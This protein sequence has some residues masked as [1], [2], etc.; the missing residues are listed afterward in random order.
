M[1]NDKDS[2]DTNI[3]PMPANAQNF[4]FPPRHQESTFTAELSNIMDDYKIPIE[5]TYRYLIRTHKRFRMLWDLFTVVLTFY[6]AITVP[7]FVAFYMDFEVQFLLVNLAI[8]VVFVVDILLN[9]IT[10]YIDDEGEVTEYRKIARNYASKMFAVDLISCLPFDVVLAIC[11]FR[12]GHYYFW[13]L[14][15]NMFKMPKLA[16]TSRVISFWQASDEAK[17]GAKM[18]LLFFYICLWVHISGCLWF[19]EITKSSKWT[20]ALDSYKTIEYFYDIDI[21]YQYFTCFYYG[22]WLSMGNDVYPTSEGEYFLSSL[23]MIIGTV[24]MAILLGEVAVIMTN[25]N[26]QQALFQEILDEASQNLSNIGINKELTLKVLNRISEAHNSLRSH[27]E[28]EIFQQYVS[29]SIKYQIAETLYDPVLS[30][31]PVFNGENNLLQFLLKKMKIKFCKDE[32]EIIAEGQDSNCMYFLISG[33]VK[34]LAFNHEEKKNSKVCFL[35]P[36]SHFGEIGLIYNT[37][38]R[39]TAIAEGYCTTAELS[40]NDFFSLTSMNSNVIPKLREFTENYSDPA[41]M[42]ISESLLMQEYFNSLP[43]NLLHEVPFMMNIKKLEKGSYL[44]KPG[45]IFKNI[46]ILIEG[47]LELSVSINDKYIQHLKI[48][49]G[50]ADVSTMRKSSSHNGNADFSKRKFDLFSV[51]GLKR[52]TELFPYIRSDGLISSSKNEST[53][54]INA[55][56]L[57]DFIQEIVLLIIKPGAVLNSNLALCSATTL[58]QCKALDSCVL[59]YLPISHIENFSKQNFSF[60]RAVYISHKR[61]LNLKTI[62]NMQNIDVLYMNIQKNKTSL[63]W[64]EAILKVIIKNR[65]EIRKRFKNM[66][67][68]SSKLRAILACEEA[69]NKELA[70]KVVKGE[71]LP[72]LISEDG[73]MISEKNID[74]TGLPASHP[75]IGKFKSALDELSNPQGY[76]LTLYNNFA[77]ELLNETEKVETMKKDLSGIKDFLTNYIEKNKG[78]SIVESKP[79]QNAVPDLEFPKTQEIKAKKAHNLLANLKNK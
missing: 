43:Q 27:E 29:P 53:I 52:K 5:K 14:L 39:A 78:Q 37:Q 11:G 65:T 34:I 16:R 4:L 35:K 62:E 1:K 48:D 17:A 54:P 15:I 60:N 25:L 30:K 20:P 59:Y 6:I 67:S 24:G 32:E 72:D 41:K 56:K 21:F 33:E 47:T 51:N 73:K 61:I 79:K 2:I 23:L 18:G 71:V 38:R 13:A 75:I 9:F 36:G 77:K 49:E 22:V 76:T 69:G 70:E 57:G 12:N 26:Q 28:Y 66:S 44:F 63:L 58:L 50:I 64:K 68:L 74:N 3:L 45:D 40:K 46:I 55:Q 7:F 10:S 19:I 8:D 42:F 31:N